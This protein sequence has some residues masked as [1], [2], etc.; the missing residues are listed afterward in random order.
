MKSRIM[1]VDNH[2]IVLYGLTQLINNC[3]DLEVSLQSDS[4]EAAL[5]LL[6]HQP[7]PDLV[8]TD[9]SLPGLSGIDL[10]KTLTAQFPGLQVLVLS[11]HD[12]MIHAERALRAGAKGYLS[13]QDASDNVVF[14]IRRILG[15][16]NYLSP[17]MQSMLQGQSKGRLKSGAG[18]VLSTLTDREYEIFASSAWA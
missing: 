17:K 8:V 4:A 18:S 5:A 14:A 6:Q 10:I 13:K 9:I 2:A 15:G 12:E 7:P 11:T 16:D 1:V 3:E